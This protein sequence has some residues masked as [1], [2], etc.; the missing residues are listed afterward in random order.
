MES[1]IHKVHVLHPTSAYANT[2]GQMQTVTNHATV[3]GLIKSCE[4][5]LLHPIDLHSVDT[6]KTLSSALT[7][8]NSLGPL[9]FLHFGLSL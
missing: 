1:E 9:G 2:G 3:V 7:F 5:T 8:P 6:L 4:T